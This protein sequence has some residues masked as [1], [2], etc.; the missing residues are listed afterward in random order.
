[1]KIHCVASTVNP[2]PPF[3]SIFYSPTSNP[4]RSLKSHLSLSWLFVLPPRSRVVASCSRWRLARIHFLLN[5]LYL[6]VNTFLQPCFPYRSQGRCLPRGAALPSI[7]QKLKLFQ[8]CPARAAF[9]LSPPA[10]K[11]RKNSRFHLWPKPLA[12]SETRIFCSS[13]LDSWLLIFFQAV[14]CTIHPL[15]YHEYISSIVFLNL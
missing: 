5:L 7:F 8:G 4:P 13:P 14:F 10:V 1:V 6:L 11:G 9:Y 3:F 15:S 12:N 2:L